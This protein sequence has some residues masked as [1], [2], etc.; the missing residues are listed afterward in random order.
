MFKRQ[1]AA[2][3]TFTALSTQAQT[4]R[5]IDHLQAFTKLYG[6][7]RYFH[8]SDM[9]TVT[10]W[11]QFAV[12]GAAAVEK[13]RDTKELQSTLTT[14][15]GPLAPGLTIYPKGAPIAL[16][17]IT[18]PDTTG[19]CTVAWQHYGYG[20]G[21]NTRTYNSVRA[22]GFVKKMPP[23]NNN[24][25]NAIATQLETGAARG[26][27]I[28]WSAAIKIAS[29]EYGSAQLFMRG[30]LDNDSW[31]FVA[32]MGNRQL[33]GPARD[34]K[35]DTIYGKVPDNMKALSAGV[36]IDR[37]GSILVD[38]FKLEMETPE[39][40]QSI[41]L[42]NANFEEDKTGERPA[43][44]DG[45]ASPEVIARVREVATP[46]GKQA[47]SF[48]RKS[49]G[50]TFPSTKSIFD[51]AVKPGDRVIKEIG[52]GLE[53]NMPVALWGDSTGTYPRADYQSAIRAYETRI[54]PRYSA[55]SL[56]VRL[57]NVIITWNV[58]QHF[59]P[60][61]QEWATDWNN[62]L[63]IALTASYTQAGQAGHLRSMQRLTARLRDGHIYVISPLQNPVNGAM[64]LQLKWVE[65]RLLI[66]RV[67]DSSLSIQRGAQIIAINGVP[68]EK[69][70]SDMEAGISGGTELA[71]RQTAVMLMQY[72][73]SDSA[74]TLG[75]RSA[76]T[77]DAQIRIGF[78]RKY[79]SMPQPAPAP[80]F[81]FIDQKTLYIALNRITWPELQKKL[82]TV[83]NAPV[84]VLDLR[85]YPRDEA[86]NQLISR[87][88]TTNDSSRWMHIPCSWLPDHEET[89]WQHLGWNV[90]PATPHIKGKV[91][92]LTNSSAISWAE[93]IAGYMK[94]MKLATIVGEST[95]GANGDV[96][97]IA[98]LGGYQV[99]FSGLKVTRH[100]GSQHY[101]KGIP[102]DVLVLP[103]VR[104]T[105]NGEDEIL[106]KALELS[107]K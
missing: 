60:Y 46:S 19:M 15:F 51:L 35:R 73:N 13:A 24:T 18:P 70:I 47:V 80:A 39:G 11:D 65:D 53:I 36:F 63:R 89:A 77:K 97:T 40:W 9:A 62:D 54:N 58:L 94:D 72:G 20:E 48:E 56:H 49:P 44:W 41:P 88:A 67:Y 105:L 21:L 37:N 27:R 61:Y 12:T 45:A 81:R 85:G 91:Y 23:A 87:L 76:G 68:T 32:N 26:K 84:L 10:D 7:V 79:M 93:S 64:P 5:Q 96:N 74:L 99:R 25:V 34:W 104:G 71:I 92:F 98:L 3:F 22:N 66:T 31:V 6:Y 2:L 33:A 82:D 43:N 75:I 28:R 103:T 100:D 4:S 57:A 14:L 42:K 102:P 69:F 83:A 101:M 78:N 30:Q 8:P 29:L 17:G 95:S 90:R 52:A 86:A 50:P 106:N 59:H 38:D 107:R 55:D 1:L 16:P